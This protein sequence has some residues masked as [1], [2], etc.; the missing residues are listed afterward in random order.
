MFLKVL[1]IFGYKCCLISIKIEFGIVFIF[2]CVDLMEVL[3]K[4]EIKDL[5]MMC[6]II[7]MFI[8]LM[9]FVI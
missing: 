7:F 5:I 4:C 9:C 8:F 3:M 2:G 1:L 6:F